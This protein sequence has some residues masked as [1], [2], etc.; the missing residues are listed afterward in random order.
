M[1]S[2][3]ADSVPRLDRSLRVQCGCTLLVAMASA[4]VSYRH[5]RVFALRFGA[6]ES[7]A[8]LWPLIVDGLLL[9]AT[10]E[11]WKNGHRN[12]ANGQWKAWLAFVLGIGLSLCANIASAPELGVF[13]V[14]VAA[15]PPL[16]LLLSV[17]LL[18]EALKRHREEIAGGTD[19]EGDESEGMQSGLDTDETAPPSV[20]LPSRGNAC[21]DVADG[22]DTAGDRSQG[23]PGSALRS[24][25]GADDSLCARAYELDAEHWNR[26]QRP[27]SAETLREQLRIGSGRARALIHHVR[28]YRQPV[29]TQ[30]R[31]LE[32]SGARR[33]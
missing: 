14:M 13:A 30:S 17:E 26:Y 25:I 4:Y 27:I 24:L 33:T 19:H 6:D 32:P 28:S 8:T 16:A 10:I 29:G 23:S 1:R 5:G 22:L 7:T 9:M 21:P 15:C 11:L 20:L 2:E 3:R 18:N 12:R 31:G